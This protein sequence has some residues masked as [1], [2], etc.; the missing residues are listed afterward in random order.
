[1]REIGEN[2]YLNICTLYLRLLGLCRVFLRF[3][4]LAGGGGLLAFKTPP[5]FSKDQW[6]SQLTSILSKIIIERW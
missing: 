3:F 2:S 1:M 4:S 5:G 6:K